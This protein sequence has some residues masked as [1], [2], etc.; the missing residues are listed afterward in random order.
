MT[1][2]TGPSSATGASSP[3]EWPDPKPWWTSWRPWAPGSWSRCGP[4]SACCRRTTSPCSSGYLRS[5]AKRDCPDHADWPDRGSRVRAAGFR[6]TTPPTRT[7]PL[8]WEQLRA[9]YYGDGIKVFWLDACEPEIRPGH[10]DN[11]R[12]AAGPGP[13]VINRYPPTMPAPST[14]AWHLSGETEVVS[15]S[16]RHGPGGQRGRGTCGRATSRPLGSRSAQVRA[17]LNMAHLGHPM[18]DDRH[19]RV[20]GG[21]PS[22]A[23]GEL[24]VR[25]FQY[26]VWCPL[27]QAARRPLAPAP[28]SQTMSGGPNEVWSYGEEVVRILA[29]VAG[30]ADASSL[31]CRAGWP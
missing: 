9:N 31:T 16:A 15:L 26:G 20:P 2:S 7:P 13:E 6:S 8:P 24:I 18:V 1:S 28:L 30:S 14:R 17:G 3:A 10:V 22:P 27:F 21:D 4:R 19:R 23:Y 12:L 11:L 5:P 29:G 25:W